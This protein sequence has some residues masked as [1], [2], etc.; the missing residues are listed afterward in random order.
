MRKHSVRRR[1]QVNAQPR[2]TGGEVVPPGSVLHLFNVLVLRSFCVG[3][4]L[5]PNYV[6]TAAHCNA[7]PATS[8]VHMDPK[9]KRRNMVFNVSSVLIHPK[10]KPKFIK[11]LP[12]PKQFL[13]MAGK[14][15]K[16]F[17]DFT[18][19]FYDFALLKLAQPFKLFKFFPCLPNKNDQF[20]GK[21][22]TASGWGVTEVSSVSNRS[23]SNVLKS[24]PFTVISDEECGKI[25]GKE[26]FFGLDINKFIDIKTELGFC[27]DGRKMNSS[28]CWGD[29]G[30][31]F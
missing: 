21:V 11:D 20:V 18:Y 15:D 22:A 28:I 25:V 8:V 31:K 16:I 3:S 29:S 14:L 30:G 4:L 9:D 12:I 7:K 27:A 10:Y 26:Y 1:P 2:I 6:L 23:L 5:S 24:A 19:S 17:S 13:E